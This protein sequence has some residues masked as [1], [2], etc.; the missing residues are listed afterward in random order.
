MKVIRV[1]VDFEPIPV[2]FHVMLNLLVPQGELTYNG[3]EIKVFNFLTQTST[4]HTVDIGV[5]G[6]F[7][8]GG[9]GV[10]DYHLVDAFIS[11]VAVSYLYH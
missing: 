5:P 2:V 11:A 1:S 4:K 8:K 3:H 9:H 10:A 6:S 7:G